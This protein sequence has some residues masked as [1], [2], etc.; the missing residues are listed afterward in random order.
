MSDAK[1]TSAN[2]VWCAWLRTGAAEYYSHT[3]EGQLM[4]P[5]LMSKLDELKYAADRAQTWSLSVASF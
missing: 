5:Q 4:S 1:H 2:G 3:E